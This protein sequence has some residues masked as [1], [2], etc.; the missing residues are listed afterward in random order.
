MRKHSSFC[1]RVFVH[2]QFL[3]LFVGALSV[4]V[5]WCMSE[6]ISVDSSSAGSVKASLRQ[7]RWAVSLSHSFLWMSDWVRQRADIQTLY[8]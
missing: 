6:Y 4:Q 1:L 7:S 3:V 5:C 8:C 2:L